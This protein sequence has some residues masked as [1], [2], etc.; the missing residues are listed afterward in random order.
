MTRLPRRCPNDE[1]V[2][3]GTCTPVEEA[4]RNNAVTLRSPRPFLNLL[5]DKNIVFRA[6]LLQHFRPD[7]YAD[8]AQMSLMKQKHQ[9]A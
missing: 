5:Q 3:G 8:F 4:I 9:G 2:A 1:V 7:R 6:H